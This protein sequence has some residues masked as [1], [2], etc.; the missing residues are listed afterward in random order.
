MLK[1]DILG[2]APWFGHCARILICNVGFESR[3]CQ[4]L[5]KVLCRIV[6]LKDQ[7]KT[8][9]PKVV[10]FCK[11]FLFEKQL[12]EPFFRT[13]FPSID[14]ICPSNQIWVGIILIHLFML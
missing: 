8:K 6:I 12:F 9:R 1:F 2:L 4:V 5:L 11:T 3:L 10:T 13:E 7:N 14:R